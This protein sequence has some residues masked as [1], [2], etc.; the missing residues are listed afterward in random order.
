MFATE[1]LIV[2]PILAQAF[3]TK[4]FAH[5]ATEGNMFVMRGLILHICMS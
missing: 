2:E 3:V 1:S 4:G 5:A